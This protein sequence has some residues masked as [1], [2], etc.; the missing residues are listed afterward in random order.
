MGR[1]EIHRAVRSAMAAVPRQR[2][3]PDELADEADEDRALP[4]G[5]GQTISQPY[6]VGLMTTALDVHA[7]DRVLEIGTG[8]G[9]QA[10]VLDELGA[11]VT[12]LEIIPELAERARLVLSEQ[13]RDVA[14]HVADGS[15]GWP[16]GAPYDGIVVTAAPETVPQALLDQLA[17]G[18]RLVVP[19]GAVGAVQ[20]LL[21]FT[22]RHDGTV[23]RRNLAAVRFVPFT[24]QA[25]G[26]GTPPPH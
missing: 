19:V 10:A 15:A 25:G 1:H 3:V 26:S 21:V 14:V 7:G 20:D 11:H 4:I 24:G 2:F 8:S 12:S 17:P 9:Y 23:R 16:D 18:G 22:T 13:G 5:W 6:I